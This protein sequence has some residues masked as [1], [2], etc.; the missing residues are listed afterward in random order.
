MKYG[1]VEL[2]GKDTINDRTKVSNAKQLHANHIFCKRE[3]TLNGGAIPPWSSSTVDLR[4]RKPF[5]T[6]PNFFLS[7]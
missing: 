6:T 7:L 4:F 2:N 3:Q 5:G 1:G